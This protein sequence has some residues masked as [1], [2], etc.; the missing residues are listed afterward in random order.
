[1]QYL[2]LASDYDGTLARDGV[3]DSATLA[4]LERFR[5]SG[6]K[7][8]LVTG[9]VLEELKSVFPQLDLFDRVVAEN[10]AVLYSPGTR[11]K[12]TLAEPAPRAFFEALRRRGVEPLGAGDVIISTRRPAEVEMIKIIGELGL[13]LQVIFNKSSVMI[14]PSGVNKRTG[15]AAALFDLCLS[16]H[17]TVGIGDAEND[18]AFLRFCE[19]SAAV[20]N[21]I[22]SVKETA[23]V[24][25]RGECGAGV[26]E[27][28]D[29][30]LAGDALGAPGR[31]RILIGHEQDREVF[32]P[33]WDTTLMVAGTSGG[34]K[35]TFVTGLVEER[36]GKKYQTCL[37]DP[38]GDY[39]ALPGAI[40]IGDENTAPSVEA[41]LQALEKPDSQVVV[42][43][44]GVAM[45]DRPGFFSVL[46]PK[47]QEMRSRIGRPHWIIVDEAHHMM[48][49]DWAPASSSDAL[50]NLVLITIHPDHVSPAALQAVDALIAVGDDAG[51]R[52]REFA[53][54]VGIE[55]PQVAEPDLPKHEAVAWLLKNGRP[56]RVRLIESELSRKRHKRK[57]ARGD[58]GEDNSFYFRGAREKLNLR[59]QN[60]MTFLQMAD[61]VDDE[62]W[63]YHLK[64]HDYSK[65]FREKIK[66]EALAREAAQVESSQRDA[67]DGRRRIRAA[68][69][70]RYTGPE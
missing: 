20:A 61:G 25:T 64:K 21:A 35:S 24:V 4:A 54:S 22:P 67:R 37:I 12:R 19:A 34:G 13:E 28:I 7:L 45:A 26:S 5:Q 33:A 15:L 2:A 51:E 29:R 43:M 46:L 49:E 14:L 53:E 40:S 66:D 59:A 65:W 32:V 41:V 27:L 39:E 10:G 52:V 44:L 68:I 11:Q 1:V 55:A 69:E 36:I 30:I 70:R 23:G 9:R 62:T 57:Y 42:N 3:V 16:E 56:R 38:E 58:L 18:H 47:L 31:C 6:R 17:N 50:K 63:N 8:I 60:L 48:P